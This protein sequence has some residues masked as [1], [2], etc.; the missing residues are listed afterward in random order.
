[1]VIAQ[2]YDLLFALG[3][4]GYGLAQADA[5]DYAL[6]LVLSAEGLLKGKALLPRLALEA[7]RRGGGGL[8]GG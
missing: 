7:L 6:R 2:A 1:M 4:L 3:Q 5:L 8:G